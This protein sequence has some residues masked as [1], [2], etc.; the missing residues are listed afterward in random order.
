MV[1]FTSLKPIDE[2][3]I[4]K[5]ISRN[6]TIIYYRRPFYNRWFGFYCIRRFIRRVSIKVV[7]IGLNDVFPESVH[8]IDLYEKYGLSSN[9]ISKRVIRELDK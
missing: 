5:S 4:V 6:K 7:K 2:D 8:S 9:Q 1:S 3:M